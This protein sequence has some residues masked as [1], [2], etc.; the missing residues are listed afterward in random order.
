VVTG[1]SVPE[2]LGYI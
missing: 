2:E 1:C